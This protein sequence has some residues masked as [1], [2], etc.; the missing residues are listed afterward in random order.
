MKLKIVY[1]CGKM[2]E[3]QS[4][5]SVNE[6]GYDLSHSYDGPLNRHFYFKRP[7]VHTEFQIQLAGLC[8]KQSLSSYLLSTF[9]STV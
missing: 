8:L 9:Y 7:S 2:E 5:D 1:A 4:L 3:G 6:S